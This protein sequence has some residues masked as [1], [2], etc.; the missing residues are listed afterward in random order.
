M[1]YQ[2]N[3]PVL[4]ITF[5]KFDTAFRVFEKIKEARPKKLYISSDGGR[6]LEEHRKILDFR[7]KI[8]EQIDWDCEVYTL[9][10][11]KN[12][13]C[14]YGPYNAITW[15]FNNEQQGIILEDDCLP[16]NSFF[17]FCDELLEKYKNDNQVFLISGLNFCEHFTKKLSSS[18]SFTKIAHTN[19]WASWRRAWNDVAMEYKNFQGDFTD[20]LPLFISTKEKRYWKKLFNQWKKK[21]FDQAWDYQW[22]FHI[23]FNRGVGIYPSTN[24]IQN[25]GLS[26]FY[27][28]HKIFDRHFASMKANPILFPLIH[29]KQIK[30]NLELEKED[31]H[32]TCSKS[33]CR[34]FLERT[35]RIT[36]IIKRL[37]ILE[38]N[39][40]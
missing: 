11:N 12:S 4:F 10:E 5:I 8:L 14:K 30:R 6:T 35:T 37:R 20:F 39:L 22:L 33:F 28:T 19:G 7:K 29:P 31:Y 23:W 15:F 1:I 18:Y 9:Y 25:I 2:A 16:D 40:L 32:T 34:I 3:N 26:H 17:R 27:A 24:M 21:G 38:K 13:G 36:Q